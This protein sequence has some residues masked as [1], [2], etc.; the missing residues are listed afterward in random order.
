MTD[1]P[2]CRHTVV[3][4]PPEWVGGR[5][6]VKCASCGQYEIG[7]KLFEELAVLSIDNWQI[8]LLWEEI[9]SAPAPRVVRRRSTNIVHVEAPGADKPTKLQKR[10]L[11][12]RA[13]GKTVTVGTVFCKGNG[14]SDVDK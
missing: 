6:K 10:T 7:P 2:I 1:C 14:K 11:R 5:L 4:S 8:E 9:S 3:T 12:A 13:A